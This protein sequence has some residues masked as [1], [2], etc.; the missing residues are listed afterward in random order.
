MNKIHALTSTAVQ[1]KFRIAMLCPTS[2]IIVQITLKNSYHRLMK[3]PNHLHK[4]NRKRTS[5][6]KA[7]TTCSRCL[8]NVLNIPTQYPFLLRKKNWSVKSK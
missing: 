3:L 5:T 2:K 1:K 8:S 4:L 7:C 6:L